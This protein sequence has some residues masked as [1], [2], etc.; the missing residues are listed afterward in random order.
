MAQY[1]EHCKLHQWEPGDHFLRT[2]FNEDFAKIDAALAE[3]LDGADRRA[4]QASIDEKAVCAAG[5]YVGAGG[6]RQVPLGFTPQAV[7]VWNQND[8]IMAVPGMSYSGLSLSDGG[9]QVTHI[10]NYR[11]DVNESGKTYLYFAL[12]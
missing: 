8:L 9:F 6:T 12:K 10:P 4:L 1:T 5:T 3:K 2:D 7:L 11:L